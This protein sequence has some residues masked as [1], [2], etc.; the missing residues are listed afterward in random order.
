MAVPLS[1]THQAELDSLP[2]ISGPNGP[3]PKLINGKIVTN[4]ASYNFTGLAGNPEIKERAVE[5]LRK[6]GTGSCGPPGFYGTQGN[7][8]QQNTL[9][10]LYLTLSHLQT[11]TLTW[12][13]TSLISWALRVSFFTRSLSPPSTRS[14][15]PFANVVMSLLPTAESTLRSRKAFKSRDA[16]CAGTITTTCR[17]WNMF[18]RLWR[19]RE[20]RKSCR[21]QDVSSLPRASSTMMVSCRICPSW[22]VFLLDLNLRRTH[23]VQIELKL[24]YKYR[25]I[26]DESISFGTMGRTGRGLTELYNIP[27]SAPRY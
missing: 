18:L 10:I 26:L 25:L 5:V 19:R 14:S 3:K 20:G 22:Y 2:I 1:P 6:Y 23:A 12:N 13:M 9:L 8:Q 11:Y 15:H 4:L 7:I 17:A 21:L 16:L 27:V 24:K